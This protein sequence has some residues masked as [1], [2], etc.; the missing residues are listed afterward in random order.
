M[1]DKSFWNTFYQQIEHLANHKRVKV[2]VFIIGSSLYTDKP[3]DI[4]LVI[5]YNK[6][7]ITNI[8]AF[9]KELSEDFQ[10][11][12][13]SLDIT[14]LTDHEFKTDEYISSWRKQQLPI[15]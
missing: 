6:E 7:D 8:V 14:L 2:S 12:G 1:K 4:D 13:L 15:D 11:K 10:K 3:K 9:R 5:V